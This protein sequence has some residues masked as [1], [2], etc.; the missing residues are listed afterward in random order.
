MLLMLKTRMYIAI[1]WRPYTTIFTY[2]LMPTY[3]YT[4]LIPSIHIYQFKRVEV[5]GRKREREREA[6][7]WYSNSFRGFLSSSP[8]SCQSRVCA[9]HNVCVVRGKEGCLKCAVWR[10][11][12]LSRMRIVSGIS[13]C[14]KGYTYIR[15]ELVR[16]C[17]S[18]KWLPKN[19][20]PN[21]ISRMRKH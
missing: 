12:I 21:V 7:N 3:I 9:S 10:N 20:L 8:L 18:H 6:S 11:R 16:V 2:T 14:R 4:D 15:S 5:Y 19:P 17:T 13:V 1:N